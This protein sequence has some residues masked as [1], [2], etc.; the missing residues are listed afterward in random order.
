LCILFAPPPFYFS[1]ISFSSFSFFSFSSSLIF[2]IP[3]NSLLTYTRSVNPFPDK[4]NLTSTTTQHKYNVVRKGYLSCQ[5]TSRLPYAPSQR[6]ACTRTSQASTT[7]RMS[8]APGRHTPQ[9]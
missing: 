3:P 4:P 7:T 9:P 2:S 6:Y 8:Y 1:E 5:P